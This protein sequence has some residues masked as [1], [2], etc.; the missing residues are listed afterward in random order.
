MT[1]SLRL[2]FYDS[3]LGG[4]SVVKECLARYPSADII[5][6][7]DTAFCPL[8]KQPETV[9]KN[10]VTQATH[11]LKLMGADYTIIA[12]NTA[13][14]YG[15][16][17]R[18][19][20]ENLIGTIEAMFYEAQLQLSHV[21]RPKILILGTTQTINSHVYQEGLSSLFPQAQINVLAADEMVNMV[22]LESL[23]FKHT[24]KITKV[25]EILS[26]CQGN[27]Y[28][29]VVLGCTHFSFLI[30]EIIAVIG[31]STLVIDP[32][33]QVAQ[34][35]TAINH[36]KHQ[37]K[38]TILSTGYT[39]NYAEIP[40]FRDHFKDHAFTTINLARPV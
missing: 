31:K 9:I 28:D 36:P 21:R 7:A 38:L 12:C 20:D 17:E 19:A 40:Y 29:A 3:G 16:S 8:G 14:I 1:C 23:A 25:A 18:T 13:S 22:E 11:Q 35:L 27:H 30:E 4:F 34:R 10:R 33:K 6:Y 2:A 15:L 39:L 32:A 24:H 26:P 37:S 5:Y